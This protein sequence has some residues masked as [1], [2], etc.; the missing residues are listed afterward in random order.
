MSEHET[1]N[2]TV[3]MER[4][5]EGVLVSYSDGV[6]ISFTTVAEALQFANAL[7]KICYFGV[8]VLDHAHDGLNT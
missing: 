8:D 4:V 5:G 6:T 3:T 2:I 7:L 1:E